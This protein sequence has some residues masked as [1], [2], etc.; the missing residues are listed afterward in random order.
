[1]AIKSSKYGFKKPK[2][3]QTKAKASKKPMKRPKKK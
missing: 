2:K 3:S 1:M